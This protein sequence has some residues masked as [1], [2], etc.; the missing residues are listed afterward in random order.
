MFWS[1]GW[2]QDGPGFEVSLYVHLNMGLRV[3]SI[4]PRII[5][6]VLILRLVSG[7]ISAYK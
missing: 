6:N 4:Y 1:K 7:S 5:Y 3:S 2:F